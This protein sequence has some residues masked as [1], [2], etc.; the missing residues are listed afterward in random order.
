[1]A[2]TDPSADQLS[3]LPNSERACPLPFRVPIKSE[4][5]LHEKGPCEMAQ[6]DITGAWLDPKLVKARYDR[7]LAK[8]TDL[9]AVEARTDTLL[10]QELSARN[11][12]LLAREAMSEV[13]GRTV[14]E[15]FASL[16]QGVDPG[17]SKLLLMAAITQF[18]DL[19]TP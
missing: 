12:V 1:M 17:Q 13:L 2:R 5:E 19:R 11:E 8:L 10:A 9:L 7:Q 15:P 18:G 3:E 14:D 4:E 6:F 16:R